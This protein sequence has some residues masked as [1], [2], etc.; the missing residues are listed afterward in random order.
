MEQNVNITNSQNVSVIQSAGSGKAEGLSLEQK[1]EITK[2]YLCFIAKRCETI[3]CLDIDVSLTMKDYLP[4]KLGEERKEE[5]PEKVKEKETKEAND[6]DFR[7]WRKSH[8]IGE[9]HSWTPVDV[10]KAIQNKSIVVK[11]DP[12]AGKTTLTAY[13]AYS[14]STQKKRAIP[15]YHKSEGLGR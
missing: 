4:L 7:V 14:F 6:T 9:T 2:K 8:L 3:P 1:E 13:L 5:R 15:S 10:E 12:G 11:G